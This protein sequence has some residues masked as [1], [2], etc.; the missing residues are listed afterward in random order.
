MQ[1]PT[2]LA[3]RCGGGIMDPSRLPARTPPVAPVRTDNA[4][5]PDASAAMSR[6]VHML[7]L[8]LATGTGLAVARGDDK[9]P[10]RPAG[11]A[12][13]VDDY[14]KDEVWAK[15]GQRFCLT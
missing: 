5:L 2:G 3:L 12:G 10:A 15:V 13:A 8:V 9:E 1:T 11:C 6:T 7:A 4:G 14:F